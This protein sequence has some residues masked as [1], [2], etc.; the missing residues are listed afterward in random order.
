MG[1]KKMKAERFWAEKL[2]VKGEGCGVWGEGNESLFK[3]L[4]ASDEPVGGRLVRLRHF[5]V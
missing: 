5:G 2:G 3:R 1:G 4:L